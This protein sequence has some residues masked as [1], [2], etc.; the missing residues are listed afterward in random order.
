MISYERKIGVV[1]IPTY[2]KLKV[3]VLIK[4]AK[5]PTGNGIEG[6]SSELEQAH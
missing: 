6:N 3:L 2:K 1:C 4:G 5:L